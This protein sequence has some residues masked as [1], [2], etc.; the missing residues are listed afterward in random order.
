MTF[1][2]FKKIIDK[3]YKNGKGRN[4]EFYLNF[5]ENSIP[6]EI[7]YVSQYHIIRDTII[8]FYVEEVDIEVKKLNEKEISY[9]K[10]YQELKKQL[11]ELEEQS[12]NAINKQVARGIVLI[13][14]QK[15]FI[16][17]LKSMLE[18]E[19]DNFS[20]ARVKDVLLKYKKIIGEKK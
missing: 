4:I 11:K 14:Q 15:E 16:N 6:I 5:G 20:V 19:K 8:V 12:S 7:D 17:Y 13:N 2:E 1:N 9:K 10:K 3:A 18:N